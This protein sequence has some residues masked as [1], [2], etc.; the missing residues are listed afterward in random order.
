MWD[1]L[2]SL[3][4]NQTTNTKHAVTTTID[5]LESRSH[6]RR[7]THIRRDRSAAGLVRCLGLLT[8]GHHRSDEV[9]SDDWGLTIDH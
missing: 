5:R 2:A 6:K 9:K 3:S 4:P 8:I 1:R 7:R